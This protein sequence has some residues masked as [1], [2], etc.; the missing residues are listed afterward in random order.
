[1]PASLSHSKFLVHCIR[2]VL[3]T[4][5]AFGHLVVLTTRS[6]SSLAA[7]NLFLRKQLALFQGTAGQ[8]APCNRLNA[9]ADGG[10]EPAVRLA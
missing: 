2:A 3:E 7:E 10:P 6:R 4:L 5:A 1:M 8:A 9:V